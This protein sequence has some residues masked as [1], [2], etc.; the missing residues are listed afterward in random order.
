MP[1][2]MVYRTMQV[3]GRLLLI[4]NDSFAYGATW[5]D[6]KRWMA[7]HGTWVEVA[8]TGPNFMSLS[9]DKLMR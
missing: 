4:A 6:I 8:M 5:V 3:V 1:P 7:L 2:N 9:S